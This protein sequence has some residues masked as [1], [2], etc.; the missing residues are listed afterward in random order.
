MPRSKDKGS[1]QRKNNMPST[2][3]Y[4]RRKK[5]AKKGA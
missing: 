1:P 5:P 4:A 3:P 2:P